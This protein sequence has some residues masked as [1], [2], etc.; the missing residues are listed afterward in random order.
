M[1]RRKF[2]SVLGGLST[3]PGVSTGTAD[4][5]ERDSD[6]GMESD[7]PDPETYTVEIESWDGTKL[8]ADLYVPGSGSASQPAIVHTHGSGGDRGDVAAKAESAAREGYAVLAPDFRGFGESGGESTL[9]GPQEVADVLVLV[10]ELAGGEFS[11]YEDEGT[12]DVSIRPSANGPTVGMIGTSLGGAIQLLTAAATREW[13]DALDDLRIS[14]VDET[15]PDL[16]V[17]TETDLQWTIEETR[18]PV[19]Y[20]AEVPDGDEIDAATPHLSLDSSPLDA[21][22]PRIPWQD[23]SRAVAPNDVVK[24]T[25]LAFLNLPNGA[26]D[27]TDGLPALWQQAFVALTTAENEF[28]EAAEEFFERRTPDL[29]AIAENDV[30]TLIVE[31]WNDGYIPPGH[32]LRAFRGIRDA[33][34][35]SPPVG[36]TLSPLEER[37]FTH[38]WKYP[39]EGGPNEHVTEYLSTVT[40]AWQDRFLK[41]DASPWRTN[42]FPAISLYQRQYPD[43]PAQYDDDRWPGWRDL[44]RFPPEGSTPTELALSTASATDRT[45]LSNTVAPTSARGPT[46]TLFASPHADAPTSSAGYDF[47]ATEPVDVATTPGLT[48]S[49]TPLGDDAVVFGKFKLVGAGSPTGPVIDSQVMPYRIRDAAGERTTV[50]YDLVPFQRYVDPGDRLRLVLAT[51]DNGYY[52]SRESAGVIVHH[53]SAEESV[54]TVETVSESGAPFEGRPLTGNE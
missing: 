3:V 49:V 48:L 18:S 40:R 41:G 33:D 4:A 8:V 14:P 6:D 35:G 22:V 15:V 47:V 30:P 25:W 39:W 2:V 38:N 29:A 51:T 42:E 20:D 53:G 34:T 24:G 7:A 50:S 54:A 46:G 45:V 17:E 27:L 36:L 31:E 52:N 16:P 13:F 12:V 32:G 21:I 37:P 23:L 28:P 44:E 9:N 19:T 5:A 43:V 11:R 1:N 10:D 26:P